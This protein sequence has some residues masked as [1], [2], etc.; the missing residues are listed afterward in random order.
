MAQHVHPR[1]LQWL[2]LNYPKPQIDPDWLK[3]CSDWLR[4]DHGL[5]PDSNFHAF[6]ATFEA[7]LLSS[8]L[9]DSM[10]HGTGLPTHAARPDTNTIL[11]GPP[12]LVEIAAM[13]EI[14][15][16]A[17]NLEQIRVAREER[18][19]AGN[20][21]DDIDTEEGDIDV[22]QGPP[23]KYPR[24]MLKFELTDG[25]ISLPAIEYRPLP[26]VVL[27]L[28]PLGCKMHLKNVKIRNGIAWLE[29]ETVVLKGY[30]N[31]DRD[32]NQKLD[33]ARGLRERMGFPLEP[34]PAPTSSR[35][36][37]RDIPPPPQP[38]PFYN[39]DEIL[40]N[41]K[42]RIPQVS[43]TV[44]DAHVA[45]TQV[46]NRPIASSS[47]A[48]YA[49]ARA[50]T[51]STTSPYFPSASQLGTQNRKTSRPLFAQGSIIDMTQDD[52]DK[53]N[54][55]HHNAQQRIV[56]SRRVEEATRTRDGKQG[57]GRSADTK[58]KGINVID[59]DEFDESIF[60]D[61]ALLESLD[62]AEM[63][64]LRTSN[65][66][67]PIPPSGR[68]SS[69]PF[70]N[71]ISRRANSDVIELADDD[72]DDCEDKEN[73]PVATRHVRQR[74]DDGNISSDPKRG[75]QPVRDVI[76]LSDSD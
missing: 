62:R 67:T 40:E 32:E 1:L 56:N 59:E 45:P 73:I 69:T 37:L 57:N 48:A 8:D 70:S 7:Q 75:S 19:R 4:A 54:P 22:D 58:G 43:I 61:Q 16:S 25:A 47:R 20:T 41:R 72:D 11:T 42:R 27:D 49:S 6:I 50:T 35:S 55:T 13:T 52:I 66:P 39:D 44:T 17:F 29:P 34:I 5:S 36:P 65:E 9:R 33:F 53:P 63:E 51:T 14:A 60:L 76:D 3:D 30:S 24:G 46:K 2:Q 21:T 38:E 26:G 64:A 74:T 10:L 68:T 71:G 31:K 12:V 23:P 18:M 28:T 15:H